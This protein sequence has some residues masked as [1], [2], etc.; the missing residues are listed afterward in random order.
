M[1]QARV[2]GGAQALVLLVDQFPVPMR[3]DVPFRNPERII[4]TPVINA[5][6]LI[7]RESLA[8]YAVQALRQESGD[9]VDGDD[10]GESHFSRM[11]TISPMKTPLP[12]E[13]VYRQLYFPSNEIEPGKKARFQIIPII[14]E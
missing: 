8:G 4:R 7:I 14:V 1:L 11:V 9:I 12:P 5:D 3:I 13:T 6:D 2:P 10:D